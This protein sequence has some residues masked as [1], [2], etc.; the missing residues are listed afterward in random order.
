[1]LPSSF[2]TAQ[3]TALVLAGLLGLGSLVLHARER[4]RWAL[5][6]LTLAAFILRL[7]TITL[8]P[9]LNQWDE[10]FHAL[11]AKNM[12]EHP[13]T[14][15]LHRVPELPTDALWARQHIWLHKPPFFLWQMALSLKVFGIHPWAVRLPSALWWTALVPVIARMGTLLSTQRVGYIT[16]VFCTFAWF[17]Q[18]LIAGAIN[19]DHNDAVFIA[20]VACSWW[21]LLEHWHRPSWK[22]ALAVGLFSAFAVLTKWYIGLVVF[23]P[24]GLMALRHRFRRSELGPLLIGVVPLL[25]LA[26]SWLAFIRA[27]FP[28]EAA[29]EWGFKSQHFWWPMDGHRGPATYHADV[30]TDLLPPFHWMLVLAALLWLSWRTKQLEHRVFLISTVSA[31]HVFFGIAQSK[32]PCYTMVLFPLYLI[33]LAHAL[34]SLS[35]AIRSPRWRVWSLAISTV[36]LVPVMLDLPRTRLYH[37]VQVPY[38]GHQEWR[39]Q[40][41]RTIEPLQ[42]LADRITDP[43]HAVVFNVPRLHHIQF[44]FSSGIESWAKMLSATEVERLTRAGYRVY[45]LQDGVPADQFPPGTQLIPDSAVSIPR[46]AR[47]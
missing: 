5:V 17:P 18:E 43:A 25:V 19:T 3:I 33:A 15:M 20:T 8:D 46:I 32:M 13:F 23:L 24:W 35:D 22:W 39:A 28:T 6:A 11:V 7:F 9:F 2:D 37:T 36:A 41:L 45:A 38:Q 29:F 47:M 14:P 40:Q 27:R 10:C 30:I 21:A 4:L 44:T 16:A 31:I 1:M 42:R 12:M 34:V 26:G